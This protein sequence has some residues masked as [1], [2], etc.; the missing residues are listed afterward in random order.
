MTVTGVH[1]YRPSCFDRRYAGRPEGAHG[2]KELAPNGCGFDRPKATAK[3]EEKKA[4]NAGMLSSD[5]MYCHHL[6]EVPAVC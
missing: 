4:Y 6:A 2:D 5:T 3:E 1:L